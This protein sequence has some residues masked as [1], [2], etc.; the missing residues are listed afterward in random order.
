MNRIVTNI[1]LTLLLASCFGEFSNIA[2]MLTGALSSRET[3]APPQHVVTAALGI[4]GQ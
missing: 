3:H 2:R 4:R 1:C